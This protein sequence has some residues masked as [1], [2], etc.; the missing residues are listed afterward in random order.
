M[1]DQEKI[2]LP[3]K[4]YLDYFK[5]LIEFISEGSTHL[6]SEDDESFIALFNSLSEDAQCLMV[7]MMNR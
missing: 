6:L 4:Y 3:Q 2:I 1:A 7:R 5:Y